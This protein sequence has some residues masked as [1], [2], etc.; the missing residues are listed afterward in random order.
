MNENIILI[1]GGARSGKSVFAQKLAGK[2]LNNGKAAYI[3]S[4]EVMDDEFRNRI[5]KHK[6]E[7]PDFFTTIEEPVNIDKAVKEIFSD[8]NVFLFDCLTTWLGNMYQ[9]FR[10]AKKRLDS[11]NSILYRLI[12][13]FSD[14]KLVLNSNYKKD[15]LYDLFEEN[16]NSMISI[17]QSSG[18]S[19]ILQECREKK[20]LIMVTNELGM[21]IVPDNELARDF[22][23]NMGWINQSLASIS[24]HV[25][26]T[27]S[28]IPVLIK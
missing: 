28:G 12:S 19:K 18:I 11:I 26:F 8:Y 20:T 1:T 22:R 2:I 5:E 3:A 23:D 4:G 7:R 16:L 14:K 27:I 13:L 15:G 25:I 10:N 9:H 17:N 21:G 6:N 24:S